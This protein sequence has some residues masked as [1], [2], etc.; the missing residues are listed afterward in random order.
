MVAERGDT[1]YLDVPTVG[2]HMAVVVRTRGTDRIIIYGQTETHAGAHIVDTSS[3]VASEFPVHL[4]YATHFHKNN[5]AVIPEGRF[6]ST[7]LGHIYD[8]HLASFVKAANA[9]LILLGQVECA[10]QLAGHQCQCQ[11]SCG[12]H[13]PPC[14]TKVSPAV[15]YSLAGWKMTPK[16]KVFC[17]GCWDL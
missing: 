17:R 2:H 6:P 1:Y 7:R 11:G 15:G 10:M 4:R 13:S 5:L 9:G 8:Q 12:R 3:P 14:P 16:N